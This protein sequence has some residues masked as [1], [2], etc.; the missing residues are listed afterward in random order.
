MFEQFISHFSSVLIN[1][2]TFKKE[3]KKLYVV[4]VVE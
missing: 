3:E 1:I 4:T 2:E